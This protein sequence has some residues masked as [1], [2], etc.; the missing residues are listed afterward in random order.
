[1]TN[2]LESG[3]HT[4]PNMRNPGL[5]NRGEELEKLK[6]IQNTRSILRTKID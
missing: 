2:G 3:W 4:V 1:M 6:A 5:Y